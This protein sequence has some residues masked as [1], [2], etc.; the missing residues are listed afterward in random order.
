MNRLTLTELAVVTGGNTA[1][2]E[3]YLAELRKRYGGR[4]PLETLSIATH[5]EVDYLMAL[6]E[7]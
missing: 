1:A 2:A 3:K 7:R 4:S 6:Y 5:E